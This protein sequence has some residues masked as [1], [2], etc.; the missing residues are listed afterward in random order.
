MFQSAPLTEARGD[1]PAMPRHLSHG[2]FNPLPSPKQ[3]ETTI[4]LKIPLA[5]FGFNPLPSP[6]QGETRL[7][8]VDAS[9]ASTFQSA[10]LTEARGDSMAYFRYNRTC[11]VSIRSPH[12]SKGRPAGNHRVMLHHMFQSAPLTEARG[13]D[14]DAHLCHRVLRVSIRSPHRSKGRRIG[15]LLVRS[16]F[17]VSIR[18]PHRSKG[19]QNKA[20]ASR[21]SGND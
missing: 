10:P 21:V 19:R 9:D 20:G 2:R 15:L 18:S 14:T 7:Y 4:M 11:E 16:L 13:D 5:I 17:V 12:R 8:S 6:K 1:R 3:G